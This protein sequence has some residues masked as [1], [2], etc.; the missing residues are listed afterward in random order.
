MKYC[1]NELS[2]M[3]HYK[4]RISMVQYEEIPRLFKRQRSYVQD[5][6][7]NRIAFK[8]VKGQKRLILADPAVRI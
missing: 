2:E 5:M 7:C 1:R 6:L 8:G 4:I 3:L